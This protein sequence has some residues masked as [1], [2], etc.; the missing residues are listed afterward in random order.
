M[1]LLLLLITP[2][3]HKERGTCNQFQKLDFLRL[4]IFLTQDNFSDAKDISQHCSINNNDAIRL[5]L[6]NKSNSKRDY[7]EAFM[8]SSID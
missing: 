1:A 5:W 7:L 2:L 8:I 3:S 4:L 6:C